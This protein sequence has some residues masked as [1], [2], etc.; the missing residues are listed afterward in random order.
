[1]TV[2]AVVFRAE[3]VVEVVERAEPEIAEPTDAIVRVRRAGIC[4]SD[5][6][7]FHG[8]APM[9][10]G[11]TMGHEAV[12]IVE[13]VGGDVRTV[14]PGD[15]VVTSFHIA[16]GEC[17]F[18]RMG[19]TGLCEEHRILGG[20]P[21]G[22]D[23]DGAQAGAVRVPVADVNLLPVPDAVD[24]ERALFV[25]DVLTTGVYAAALAD[26]GS[27]DV[28]AIVGAG[29][30]GSCVAQALR[31]RGIQRVFASDV[32]THRLAAIRAAGVVSI[33][34]REENPEMVL[35]RAT[36]GRGAD[37]VIDA[38]GAPTAYA[39]ALEIVRRGGRVVVVGMYTSE[40]VE[41]QLG[42]SWIRGIQLVFAGET[43]V[44]SWWRQTMDAVTA[45]TLDPAPLV[46]HRL[47]IGEAPVGYAAFDRHE[48]T[49]VVLDPWA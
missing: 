20:G 26:A 2:Q 5:L 8:K 24:D 33:D 29:S 23:L 22:G 46:S 39:T 21:F 6:H 14:S 28:V 1:V 18:C 45:G 7:F 32:E 34:A 41:L 42:V 15:R 30:V 25:G 17:W 47:P 35:A 19:Q 3:G 4:G 10:P 27:D 49:K 48:A 37:V 36:D 43:P 13:R 16:C 38:V 11:T 31:A 12:G 44:H 9:E 40:T